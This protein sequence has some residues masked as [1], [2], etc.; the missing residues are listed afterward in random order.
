MS[1]LSK[2]LKSRRK[3]KRSS[4]SPKKSKSPSR[5]GTCLC[6]HEELNVS[7]QHTTKL[8]CCNR[9]FHTDC[10]QDWRQHRGY[11]CP[12]CGV[13]NPLFRVSGRSPVLPQSPLSK[14]GHISPRYQSSPDHDDF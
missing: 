5:N 13:H 4:R 14:L 12:A 9:R 7:R 3:P 8:S 2:E 1:K 10:L 6:C 11:I